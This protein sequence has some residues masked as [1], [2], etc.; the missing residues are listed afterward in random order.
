MDVLSRPFALPRTTLPAHEE[1][2]VGKV[3]PPSVRLHAHEGDLPSAHGHL[4][5]EATEH[6]QAEAL[7]PTV[8]VD[9][10]HV[11]RPSGRSTGRSTGRPSEF[12]RSRPA[13]E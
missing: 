6:I 2:S 10:H 13:A 3:V 11:F 9:D 1:Q 12:S 4:L 8:R 7:N 5:Q